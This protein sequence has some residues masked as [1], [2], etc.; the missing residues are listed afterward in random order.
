MVVLESAISV[1]EK[2]RNCEVGLIHSSNDRVLL[3]A[4]FV[5]FEIDAER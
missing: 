2:F 5:I 1:V 3:A 4:A